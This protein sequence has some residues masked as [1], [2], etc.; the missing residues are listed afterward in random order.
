V[1]S[2]AQL[3]TAC[4]ITIARVLSER[5]AI[6]C[7]GCGDEL[8]PAAPLEVPVAR[9]RSAPWR[10]AEGAAE[11]RPARS[12]SASTH[13]STP[14][15]LERQ[16]REALRAAPEDPELVRV[17]ALLYELRP[18]APDPRFPP[19]AATAAPLP[20]V[21]IRDPSA[22]WGGIPRGVDFGSV[23]GA[24]AADP[25]AAVLSRIATFP[26]N[27][28]ILLRWLREHASLEQ[29]LRGL[30]VDVGVRFADPAQRDLWAASLQARRDGAAPYG[31]HLVLAA[32]AQW[33][34]A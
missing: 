30:Y 26:P 4:V 29:G 8:R 23:L 1:T 20:F 19:V 9:A 22:A 10:R 13:A 5:V 3:C 2:D 6:V 24:A 14:S 12:W 28:A 31:R 27:D 16:A 21:V 18:D 33:E 34:R 7:P 32:A 17:R 25:G 15:P 11:L